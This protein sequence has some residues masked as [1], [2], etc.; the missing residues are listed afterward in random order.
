MP[1]ES[2]ILFHPFDESRN[3]ISLSVH[4]YSR[5]GFLRLTAVALY[6]TVLSHL[7]S[8]PLPGE[9]SVDGPKYGGI[10]EWCG[11]WGD[12]VLSLSWDWHRLDDGAIVAAQDQEVRTNL[13]LVCEKG[14]DLGCEQ[15][16]ELLMKHIGAMPWQTEVALA[17]L[18]LT[19]AKS[20]KAGGKVFHP[21]FH[22]V[23]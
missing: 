8:E 12:K 10:T 9:Q 5:D 11:E 13:M 20:S 19:A 1:I 6:R 21:E 2:L 17:L 22:P 7:Y 3:M 23:R 4:K 16:G 15:T 18:P 14:Y